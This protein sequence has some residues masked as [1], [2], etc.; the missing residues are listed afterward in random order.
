MPPS[1]A[2]PAPAGGAPR[3]AAG[4]A[5]REAVR[6]WNGARDLDEIPARV[7][8]R[9]RGAALARAGVRFAG[10][11]GAGRPDFELAACAKVA[12][13]DAARRWALTW[14]LCATAVAGSRVRVEF[15]ATVVDADAARGAGPSLGTGAGG[16]GADG[17]WSGLVGAL[18][19]ATGAAPDLPEAQA[20]A[21]A[22]C[23]AGEA[24]STQ[25]EFGDARDALAALSLY[26]RAGDAGL[27]AWLARGGEAAGRA[28]LLGLARALR[29]RAA[30]LVDA[31][32][33]EFAARPDLPPIGAEGDWAAVPALALHCVARA[34]PRLPAEVAPWA[35]R[36]GADVVRWCGEAPPDVRAL[37]TEAVGALGELQARGTRARPA[38]LADEFL[39]AAARAAAARHAATAR[40]AVCALRGVALGLAPGAAA[41]VAALDALAPWVS[42]WLDAASRALAGDASAAAACVEDAAAARYAVAACGDLWASVPRESADLAR[43]ATDALRAWTPAALA[44]APAGVRAGL[45]VLALGRA[46]AAFYQT[47][48]LYTSPSPRDRG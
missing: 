28:L 21:H 33:R 11:D 46:A 2:A 26:L 25:S 3:D 1:P 47:C 48:L 34:C 12:H 27:R 36:V 45:P 44:A 5:R 7:W 4:A 43:R 32:R 18:D 30:D 15:V 6:A 17:G 39:G 20:R 13:T 23:L 10:G 38:P 42:A 19:D 31:Q 35:E 8:A 9:W 14:R 37:A 22:R 24:S 16:A 40:G 41:E 29:P